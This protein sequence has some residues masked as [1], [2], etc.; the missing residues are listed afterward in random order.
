MKLRIK[1]FLLAILALLLTGCS[2]QPETREE[3]ISRACAEIGQ[4]CREAFAKAESVPAEF[5]AG[6]TALTQN[7]MDAVEEC[8][9][10][11]GY[12]VLDFQGEYPEYLADPEGLYGF[13]ED[14]QAGE[15]GQTAFLRVRESGG[16]SYLEFSFDGSAGEFALADA[17]FDENGDVQIE[18]LESRRVLDWTLTEQGNFYYQI[19]PPDIHYVDYEKLRLVPPDRETYDL[20][21]KY[22]LKV[23]YQ[24]TNLFLCDWSE[25]DFGPLSFNDVFEYLYPKEEH[26][27]LYASD[28]PAYPGKDC[29]LIPAEEFEAVVMAYFDISRQELRRRA[30]YDPALDGYP[31]KEQGTNDYI[32]FPTLEPE[33]TQVREN[34]D[35][36]LTLTVN[37]GSAEVKLD[38]LFG[39]E[40]TV[41]PT[42]EGFQ[43]VSN[44]V[45]FQTAYGL[46]PTEPRL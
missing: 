10:G 46:P 37:V 35:G 30:M 5:P 13:W 14:V 28:F 34:P 11:A 40:V 19:L 12:A 44:R 42:A 29:S 24:A 38:S 15:P 20:T 43:Y 25:E 31:W 6:A 7:G 3:R 8:L 9:I 27:R 18:R 41:R 32:P 36:T 39:H 23:G 4:V 45:T 26:R 21:L 22:I 33:V 1:C 2:A 17:A 16:F